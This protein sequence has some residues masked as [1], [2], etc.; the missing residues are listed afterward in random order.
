[1]GIGAL[2]DT[3]VTFRHRFRW[4]LEVDFGED[5]RFG[6]IFVKPTAR[7]P[8]TDEDGDRTISVKYYESDLDADTLAT[9]CTVFNRLF[10]NSFTS[11]GTGKLTLYDSVGEIIEEWGLQGLTVQ[12]IN[13]GDLDFSSSEAT[14]F[15]LALKYRRA[16]YG[17]L[18]SP[19]ETLN[20]RVQTKM[21]WMKLG[22]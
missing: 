16:R 10:E 21:E 11:V 4:A 14:S 9:I 17:G 6:P 5:G 8:F 18:P 15:D 7:P 20:K 2:G 13:F 1:M 22:F 3:N 12:S 19:L